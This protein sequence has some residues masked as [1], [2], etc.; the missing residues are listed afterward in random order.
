MSEYPSFGC[1]GRSADD[2][3]WQIQGGHGGGRRS[4]LAGYGR[5]GGRDGGRGRGSGIANRQQ[6]N[7]FDHF[8]YGD[9]EDAEE[10]EIVD[11]EEDEAKTGTEADDKLYNKEDFI[12]EEEMQ[13]KRNTAENKEKK[14]E[15]EMSGLVLHAGYSLD[16]IGTHTLCAS[17]AMA[18]KLNGYSVEDIMKIGRWTSTTF[19]TYIHSQIAALNHGIAA[20]M[21]RRIAFHNVGG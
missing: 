13:L 19:L 6:K 20:N 3:G 11:D 7:R 5:H 9:F 2:G 1:G 15:E 4:S 16:R 14:N 8:F 12:T 10:D 18:L 17:G 21:S